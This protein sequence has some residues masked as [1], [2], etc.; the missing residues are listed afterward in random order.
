MLEDQATLVV[1]NPYVDH[2]VPDTISM[3][4]NFRDYSHYLTRERV[5][6]SN[7]FIHTGSVSESASAGA[8][9]WRG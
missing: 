6:S 7:Q 2:C 1:E 8:M 4:P 5:G 3:R 9:W